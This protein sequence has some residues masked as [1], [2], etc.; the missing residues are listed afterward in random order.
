[1]KLISRCDLF[2]VTLYV[3]CIV[4][5]GGGGGGGSSMGSLGGMSGGMAGLGG[6]LQYSPQLDHSL[7]DY[8]LH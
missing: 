6:K 5:M 1:M 3:V 4:D 7:N 2:V 8:L